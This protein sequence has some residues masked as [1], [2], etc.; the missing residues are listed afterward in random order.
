MVLFPNAKI[1]LGLSVT[2]KRT[3][4]FHNIETVF[5]PIGLCDVLE[6]VESTE[7]RT[8]LTVSGTC[9]EGTSEDNLVYRA[10]SLMNKNYGVPPVSIHLHKVIPT[11]AGLGGGSA[12]AAF[13]LKGLNEFFKCGADIKKLELMA[14]ALGSDCAFFIRNTAAFAEGRGEILHP[15]QINLSIHK[16]LL[17]NP[18]IHVST[19]EAYEG[20]QPQLPQVS[21]NELS[22]LDKSEW[23]RT[24]QNDFEV[25][26]FKKH[27]EIASIK[28][29]LIEAGAVYAAMSGSGSTVFGIFPDLF[30]FQTLSDNYSN[31]FC[32]VGEFI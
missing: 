20:V 13:M 31:Y 15:V 23:Q 14:A 16:V 4:G 2:S 27:P 11:G 7:G 32:W 28:E 9:L 26:V 21:L 3:D 5:L 24:I 6:F 30:D 8:K 29:K 12:D 19:R 22:K 1:N 10:W 25:S 18:G 17:I